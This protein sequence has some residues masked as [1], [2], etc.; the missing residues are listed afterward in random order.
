MNA[1]SS[2][3]SGMGVARRPRSLRIFVRVRDHRPRV[4]P[5]SRGLDLNDFDVLAGKPHAARAS[6]H[7]RRV[8]GFQTPTR[9]VERT[10]VALTVARILH[11]LVASSQ[12]SATVDSSEHHAPL[13]ARS[14]SAAG[15]RP[16]S[17]PPAPAAKIALTNRISSP[18][19]A[20]SKSTPL[21]Q[22]GCRHTLH[23]PRAST[24]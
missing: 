16:P 14:S 6:E 1:R 7:V 22:S 13:N 11:R 4:T 12:R 2:S 17:A 5:A 15:A 21:Q 23:W 9:C 20:R 10:A 24:S 18:S 8:V 3:V 19:A